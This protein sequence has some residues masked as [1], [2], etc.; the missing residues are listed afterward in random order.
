MTVTH[1]MPEGVIRQEHSGTDEGGPERL[2][3]FSADLRSLALFRVAFGA[4]VLFDLIWRVPE[5]EAFYTDQGI[6]P[7]DAFVSKFSI[8]W[9]ISLHL[10]SGAWIGQFLLFLITIAAVCGMIVGYRT[11]LCVFLAWLLVSS[12]HARNEMILHGGDDLIRVVLF[13]SMFAPLNARWSLD[14][15]LNPGTPSLPNQNS[16]WGTQ[17]LMLQVCFLYFFNGLWKWDPSWTSEGSAIYY[18]LSLDQFT[19]P[20]GKWLSHYPGFLKLMSRITVGLELSGGF[21]LLTPAW[22]GRVRLLAVLLL[23]GF[24]AGTGLT[25]VL[26]SFPWVC[27]AALLMFV[28]TLVWEPLVRRAGRYSQGLTIFF[29]GGCGFCRRGVL[30]FRELLVLTRAEIRTAQSDELIHAEMRARNSWVIRDANGELHVGYDAFVV[31]CHYSIIGRWFAPVLGSAPARAVGEKVYRSVATDRNRA[32]KLLDAVTPPPPRSRPS[33]FSNALVL[34]SIL[35]VFAG[36]VSAYPH[37]GGEQ[38]SPPLLRFASTLRL[39]Q[40]WTMFAPSPWRD[41]GWY[42]VEGYTSGDT[43]VDPWNGGPPSWATPADMAPTFRNSQWRKYL[44]NIWAVSNRGHRPYFAGYLCRT[45]NARHPL[46]EQL[47]SLVINYMLETTPPPGQP[48]PTPQKV[49]I[50]RQKCTDPPPS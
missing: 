32:A 29:D 46:K 9:T 21:L 36:S 50:W 4:C 48:T 24:H 7:R 49:E 25:L 37:M 42:V 10:M 15:A 39:G 43:V 41:D 28:P 16:W 34:A 1:S 22:N 47:D 40:R 20:L 38:L 19:Y 5:I 13:W 45:W 44:T 11:R 27:S 26:G 17:A 6:L 8:P 30:A 12:M 2:K 14:R 33:L 3:F 18:A 23:I 31:L 35:L